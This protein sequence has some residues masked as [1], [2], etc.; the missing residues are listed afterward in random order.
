MH[1]KFVDKYNCIEEKEMLDLIAIA[2]S[3]P[4]VIAVNRAIVIGYKMSS[5]IG[6]FVSV[7]ITVIP[8]F[9]I[10]SI[11]SLFYSI[12]RDNIFIALMPEGMQVG[13]GAV[14]ASVI[15]EMMAGLLKEK[16][17]VYIM[18][19][20]CSFVANY[21]FKINVVLII[22]IGLILGALQSLYRMKR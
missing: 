7:M 19:K 18:I 5:M 10:I 3:A 17:V 1:K 11:M 21:I 15:Y 4:G 12:F 20:I 6:A 8:P 14:I 2:E 22:L 13:V 16:S 9:I